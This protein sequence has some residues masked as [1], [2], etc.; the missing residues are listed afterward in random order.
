MRVVL[1]R[2]RHVVVDH[3][4]DVLDV[5]TTSG[6]RGGD[7]DVLGAVL[8]RSERVLTLLLALATVQRTGQVVHLVQTLGQHVH[9]L[10]LVHED[11]HRRLEATT[12]HLQQLLALVVLGQNV[13][14]L[15]HTLHRLADR[16]DVD[17]RR[18]PQVVACQPFDRRRHGRREHDRL[19]ELVLRLEVLHQPQVVLGLLGVRL[20][21]ADRHVVEDLLHVRLEAHVDHAIRLVEHHVGAAT[22]HQV[23]VLEDVDQTAGRCDHDLA[24]ESQLEALLFSRDTTDDRHCSNLELLRELQRFLF[25]LLSELTSGRQNDRVRS[26]VDLL[27]PHD[28]R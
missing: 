5:E 22:E 19:S 20:Q 6:H 17:H 26:L 18:S 15:L 10:L 4:R 25:D 21:V 13:D 16:A 1:D 8:Q 7:Q 24:T 14:D 11:D 23:P 2:F 28:L 3:Q 12:E 9:A 27:L